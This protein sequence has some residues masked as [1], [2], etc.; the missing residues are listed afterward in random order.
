[1]N[2]SINTTSKSIYSSDEETPSETK[3]NGKPQTSLLT[4]TATA[5]V[6][7]QIYPKDILYSTEE[8]TKQQN[9]RIFTNLLRFNLLSGICGRR[10][11]YGN[12][13]SSNSGTEAAA[14]GEG[15]TK[16][17][18]AKTQTTKEFIIPAATV[19]SLA[20]S[21]AVN[22]QLSASKK[23]TTITT[24]NTT[25][26]T[27]FITKS[28]SP[29]SSSLLTNRRPNY[30][31]FQQQ[32]LYYP[33]KSQKTGRISGTPPP[34]EL[35]QELN[36]DDLEPSTNQQ[37]QKHR[38]LLVT[39]SLFDVS[40]TAKRIAN[41]KDF[42]KVDSLEQKTADEQK[43]ALYNQFKR[44]LRTQC[45]PHNSSLNT[46]TDL[47]SQYQ[48]SF[49]FYS[50]AGTSNDGVP[51]EFPQLNDKSNIYYHKPKKVATR[52]LEEDVT[53]EEPIPDLSHFSTY[54]DYIE[55]SNN[56]WLQQ[57]KAATTDASGF[58][59]TTA[60]SYRELQQQSSL[61]SYLTSAPILLAA[62]TTPQ[63]QGAAVLLNKNYPY[64]HQNPQQ[65]IK[66]QLYRTKSSSTR[67][68]LTAQSSFTA[69]QSVGTNLSFLARQHSFD[70]D[71]EDLELLCLSDV[72]SETDIATK[73]SVSRQLLLHT[74]A[75]LERQ[76][77]LHSGSCESTLSTASTAN[78]ERFTTA[79][80]GSED[81]SIVA[82]FNVSYNTL[83][84]SS[85]QEQSQYNY[86]APEQE[87]HEY[88]PFSYIKTTYSAPI[89]TA[90]VKITKPATLTSSES[91]TTALCSDQHVKV[92]MPMLKKNQTQPQQQQSSTSIT[93]SSSSNS[94]ETHTIPT[95]MLGQ[96]TNSVECLR[97]DTELVDD[98]AAETKLTKYL[99]DSLYL[100]D[101]PNS[102][103]IK[104][105]SNK[106][107]IEALSTKPTTTNLLTEPISYQ[108]NVLT[109]SITKTTATTTTSNGS[110]CN[111]NNFSLQSNVNILNNNHKN[112]SG[113]TR[114]N[115]SIQT[116]QNDTK[117]IYNNN[118]NSA[119]VGTQTQQQIHH[120][121][122]HHHVHQLQRSSLSSDIAC[123]STTIHSPTISSSSASTGAGREQVLNDAQI[124]HNRHVV[125][126]LAN[127]SNITYNDS[128][129]NSQCTDLL[130]LH[131]SKAGNATIKHEQ[132]LSLPNMSVSSIKAS[133]ITTLGTNGSSSSSNNKASI[134]SVSG[135]LVPCTSGTPTTTA[136]NI[137]S[138]RKSS[139]ATA[140]PLKQ[141]SEISH[142]NIGAL[143]PMPNTLSTET[144]PFHEQIIMSG[145]QKCAL[146]EKPKALV[147]SPQQVMILYMHKLTPYERTEILGYPQIY[148]IGANAKKRPGIFGP[149]NSDYDNEQGAYIH[150]PHDHVAYR[151]E[152]LKIIGKGSFGQVVKAYDHKTHEHVALKMVRNEKRFHRQAQEEIRI[153][154]HLRRQDK[155]NTM[156]IIHMYDYFTF[157]NHMCIT[158]ELLNIN[159]YE[160]IK[161]NGFKGFSLQLVRK[162]AH[163]LLQCLDALY[164]NEIIHCD[165]KP[166]NVL[167]KQQGRSGIKVIDFGSSCYESQRVYTYIQSRFYR[168]PEVI[169]GAK[170]GRAID[171]WSLGCILAEL[172]TGH[173]L[174]P[175]EN[176]GDQLACIIE[177]LDMPSKTLLAN[178]KRAKAFF[179]PKGYPRYCTVRTMAD[180]VVVL[181]GGQSR[182]GKPRGPPCSKSLSKALDG[183]KDPLFLNFIRGCLEWDPDK[184][185]TP[186]EALK[187]PWLRRRLP[188][189]PSNANGSGSS[190]NN[191]MGGSTSDAQ[192]PVSGSN[193]AVASSA[194]TSSAASSVADI[195]SNGAGGDCH[196]VTSTAGNKGT[197]SSA[198]SASISSTTL[199]GQKL[200]DPLW[201]TLPTTTTDLS[202]PSENV[203]ASAPAQSSNS[204]IVSAMSSFL[205]KNSNRCGSNCQI[206]SNDGNNFNSLK[207]MPNLSASSLT[208]AT[209]PNNINNVATTDNNLTADLIKSTKNMLK[210][211][212]EKFE[213]NK[214]ANSG[215]VS[216]ASDTAVHTNNTK[217]IYMSQ[218]QRNTLQ[219]STLDKT[220]NKSLKLT[221]KQM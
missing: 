36:L 39:R 107:V 130:S 165:M 144:Y 221:S 199:S 71:E 98:S 91:N 33:H 212:N 106:S 19:F 202:A 78:S 129:R 30:A 105:I 69:S 196:T 154:H 181:I 66:T 214:I 26:A 146:Q 114:K 21:S 40:A 117:L 134:S 123:V 155:Y 206:S 74:G 153:L 171:M 131:A 125:A 95:L 216:S 90:T 151:Y 61:P 173:A 32:E 169:L 183:C 135:M 38:G 27:S 75:R 175:G 145:Q 2:N 108:T 218:N 65:N 70:D 29:A 215:A 54:K 152:M 37:A 94:L 208:N 67:P 162:F 88:I 20:K 48:H 163:S 4:T 113:T 204:L 194:V 186:A 49:P 103:Q 149:N 84:E 28:V 159:L 5:Q 14:N 31:Y 182:R 176:E 101:N 110:A 213:Q 80:D 116:I 77:E 121:N 122:N 43:P 25:C 111:N 96:R 138:T 193:N 17:D 189:P 7:S 59:T 142:S 147:V 191:G 16:T 140:S 195:G 63:K 207:Y 184:R 9:N 112:H 133:A 83:F 99:S 177:V 185:L 178:A 150:I 126:T 188:R 174:F 51:I 100:G 180:G 124:A 143:V 127:E 81:S 160:L 22:Q 12:I 58:D 41:N 56:Y 24:V 23:D 170:Y 64:Q 35:Y 47:R 89:P 72:K 205:T 104:N 85:I 179:N 11:F 198:S 192:T 42:N 34:A 197:T 167:L 217:E 92:M 93:S 87:R 52:S 187:H 132:A 50:Y 136:V 57:Q 62:L 211:A 203:A 166:E 128:K 164:K 118:S 102:T 76:Q 115:I 220:L 13:P 10:N 109:E 44:R 137:L 120:S 73:S 190:G 200:V 219:T 8:E 15:T 86:L 82:P 209:N 210:C 168:A 157:R 18:V 139:N 46:A 172:L 60:N 156:N 1:M 148:F 53:R 6:S 3:K 119:M 158:F 55:T 201:E 45:W 97:Y 68:P 161:K 141:T 79:V